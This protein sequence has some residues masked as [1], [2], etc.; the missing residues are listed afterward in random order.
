METLDL[1]ELRF[2]KK[3]I[4]ATSKMFWTL[5]DGGIGTGKREGIWE[6]QWIDWYR[7]WESD[8]FTGDVRSNELGAGEFTFF[9]Q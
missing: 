2:H 1:M 9:L 5:W 8:H 6:D 7:Q 4:D 3:W